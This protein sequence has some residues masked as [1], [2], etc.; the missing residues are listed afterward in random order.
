MINLCVQLSIDE[1]IAHSMDDTTY[2]FHFSF[3]F[4]S[5]VCILQAH[6]SVIAQYLDHMLNVTA[7]FV[8]AKPLASR[9]GPDRVSIQRWKPHHRSNIGKINI[10]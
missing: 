9:I 2:Y 3:N 6:L 10:L 4:L 8:C 7:I 1:H 5:L